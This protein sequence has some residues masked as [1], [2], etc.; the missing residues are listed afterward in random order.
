MTTGKTTGIGAGI[1]ASL[2]TLAIFVGHAAGYFADHASAIELAT[3]ELTILRDGPDYEKALADAACTIATNYVS[4]TQSTEQI[5]SSIL[6]Q[7]GYGPLDTVPSYLSEPLDKVS[8]DLS[9][10]SHEAP[11]ARGYTKFCFA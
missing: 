11:L 9:L 8:T 7:L 1:G 5:K 6:L 10:A 4:G 2:L 3:K